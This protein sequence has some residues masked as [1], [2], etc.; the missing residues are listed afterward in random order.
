MS[1][2]DPITISK[3][4]SEWFYDGMRAVVATVITGFRESRATQERTQSIAANILSGNVEQADA[5]LAIKD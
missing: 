3:Y 4:P 2:K 1:E 5:Q